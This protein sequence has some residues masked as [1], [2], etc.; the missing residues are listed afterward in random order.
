MNHAISNRTYDPYIKGMKFFTLKK[1][2][3]SNLDVLNLK[4]QKSSIL[5]A[6]FKEKK[7]TENILFLFNIVDVCFKPKKKKKKN[8]YIVPAVKGEH[9]IFYSILLMFVLGMV[10]QALT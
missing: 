4:N 5:I 1:F 3:G 2:Y 7:Y 10:L 8:T 6:N 9:I